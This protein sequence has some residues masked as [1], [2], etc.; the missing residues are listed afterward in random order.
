MPVS[1]SV[2]LPSPPKISNLRS[3]SVL[4]VGSPASLSVAVSVPAPP[5]TAPISYPRRQAEVAIVSS[6]IGRA[7]E[8]AARSHG[9]GLGASAKG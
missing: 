9:D 5:A 1:V 4:S 6:E 2:P 8:R 3:M 7:G